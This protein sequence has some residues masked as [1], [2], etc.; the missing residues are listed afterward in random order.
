[1]QFV[2]PIT[3]KEIP[4]LVSSQNFK[5]LLV[6]QLYKNCVAMVHVNVC[7]FNSLL[8][9]QRLVIGLDQRKL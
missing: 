8:K 6:I 4:K 5:S 2:V 9:V 3:V 7:W 1:M